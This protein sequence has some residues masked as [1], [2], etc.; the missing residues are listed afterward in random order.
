MQLMFLEVAQ[1][2]PST[3]YSQY[4]DWQSESFVQSEPGFAGGTAVTTLATHSAVLRL[5]EKPEG[6]S[7]ASG[8]LADL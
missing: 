5:H 4:P 6:H 7:L 1:L 8:M 3:M 2:L